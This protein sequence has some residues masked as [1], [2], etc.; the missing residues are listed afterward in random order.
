MAKIVTITSLDVYKVCQ[1]P[2][3]GFFVLK[4]ISFNFEIF[5]RKNSRGCGVTARLPDPIIWKN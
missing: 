2:L 1:P 4:G 3:R 5:P